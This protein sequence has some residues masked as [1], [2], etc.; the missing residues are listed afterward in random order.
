MRELLPASVP[1]LQG[2]PQDVRLAVLSTRCQAVAARGGSPN[3]P[4]PAQGIPN[5]IL[6][7]LEDVPSA[8]HGPVK[9]QRAGSLKPK[10]ATSP[11]PSAS[12]PAPAARQGDGVG[13]STR[14]GPGRPQQQPRPGA[15]PH[16]RPNRPQDQQQEAAVSSQEPPQTGTAQAGSQAGQGR[17]RRRV[18]YPPDGTAQE[19]T[20]PGQ[21]KNWQ[22][23][24][25]PQPQPARQSSPGWKPSRVHKN[26][27][28]SQTTS[29][30]ELRD[31]LSSWGP[32][33]IDCIHLTTAMQR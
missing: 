25:P 29:I 23:L 6:F 14:A 28:I 20:Q 8:E 24:A 27:L 31:L 3:L 9:P 4:V 26:A 10:G 12:T 2:L 13:A 19:S 11:P 30:G 16:T 22:F 17:T 33:H 15:G 21:P 7:P 1:T 32:E 18:A 5:I